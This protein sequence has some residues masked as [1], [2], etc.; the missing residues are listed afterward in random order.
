MTSKIYHFLKFPGLNV[1]VAGLTHTNNRTINFHAI[2]FSIVN[3]VSLL[4]YVSS[5]FI[6]HKKKKNVDG[7]IKNI[8][9]TNLVCQ[10][11]TLIF[12]FKKTIF[13]LIQ[14]FGLQLSTNKCQNTRFSYATYIH[15]LPNFL[16]SLSSVSL[17]CLFK[18]ASSKT[19]FLATILLYG[20]NENCLLND[21]LL[22]AKD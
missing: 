8:I 17:N 12:S 11:Q 15:N 4:V 19:T 9:C 10:R 6:L 16:F 1:L 7:N 3:I 13:D 20:E 22:Y 14:I 2:K 21:I 5:C 18:E